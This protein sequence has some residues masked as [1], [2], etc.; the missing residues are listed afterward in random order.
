MTYSYVK[1]ALAD[2]EKNPD[3]LPIVY[4]GNLCYQIW[5]KA[6]EG[7]SEKLMKEYRRVKFDT[8]PITKMPYLHWLVFYHDV[9]MGLLKKMNIQVQIYNKDAIRIS[10]ETMQCNM[11]I[12]SEYINRSYREFEADMA[13]AGDEPE[14]PPEEDLG[15]E[16]YEYYGYYA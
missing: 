8:D 9:V 2:F 15:A 6:A 13:T 1:L 4:N 16:P 12:E 7:L 3:I 5:G 11:E 10:E 14:D